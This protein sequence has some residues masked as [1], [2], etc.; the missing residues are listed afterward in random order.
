MRRCPVS[1][2]GASSVGLSLYLSLVAFP[3]TVSPFAFRDPLIL[4]PVVPGP[5]QTG[6]PRP[7]ISGRPQ[8]GKLYPCRGRELQGPRCPSPSRADAPTPAPARPAAP[9]RGSSQTV[10]RRCPPQSQSWVQVRPSPMSSACP[11]GRH[12]GHQWTLLLWGHHIPVR[13]AQGRDRARGVGA[14]RLRGSCMSTTFLPVLTATALCPSEPPALSLGPWSL[15]C[16]S[17]TWALGR[18]RLGAPCLSC[19]SCPEHLL[20]FCQ[21]VPTETRV[22]ERLGSPPSGALHSFGLLLSLDSTDPRS[23]LF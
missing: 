2:E 3:G 12:D 9:S 14:C 10:R 23:F 1:S 18:G 20:R 7:R 4:A 16:T 8:G 5:A 19:P 22:H 6:G 15:A 11:G 17:G 13:R 21:R